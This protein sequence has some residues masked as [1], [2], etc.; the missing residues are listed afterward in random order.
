MTKQQQIEKLEQELRETYDTI[1][2]LRK[3]A[4]KGFL[5]SPEYNRMN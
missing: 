5:S 1:E 2:K 3:D 4:D